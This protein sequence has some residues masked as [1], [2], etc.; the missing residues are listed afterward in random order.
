MTYQFVDVTTPEGKLWYAA[1]AKKAYDQHYAPIARLV[2]T[3]QKPH[4]P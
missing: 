1:A 4:V 3:G 2:V